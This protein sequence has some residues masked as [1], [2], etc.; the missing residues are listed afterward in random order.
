ME[1]PWQ[2]LAKHHAERV[3]VPGYYYTPTSCPVT[4]LP[5]E[6]NELAPN[7][8]FPLNLIPAQVLIMPHCSDGSD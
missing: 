5:G 7:V 1:P 6:L 3:S 2:T 4:F 8:Q